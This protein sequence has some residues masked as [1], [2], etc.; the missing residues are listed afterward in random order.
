[1]SNGSK[2]LGALLIGAAAGAILGVLFAPDKGEETRRKIRKKGED[3]LDDIKRK[4][5]EANDEIDNLSKEMEDG[6]PSANR[7]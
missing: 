5:N 3:I 4:I 6:N 2:I 7:Y 1:M